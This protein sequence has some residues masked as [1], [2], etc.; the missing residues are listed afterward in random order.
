ML[1]GQKSFE[2]FF[3]IARLVSS[4]FLTMLTVDMTEKGWNKKYLFI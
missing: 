3:K 4:S 1:Y 2:N